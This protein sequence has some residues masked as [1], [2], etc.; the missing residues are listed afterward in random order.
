MSHFDSLSKRYRKDMNMDS[1]YRSKGFKRPQMTSKVP[2]TETV[3]HMTN[4]KSRLD[5]GSVEGES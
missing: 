2:A 1:P 3:K 5:G 4:K